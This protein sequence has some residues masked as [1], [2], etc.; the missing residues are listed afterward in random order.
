MRI[1]NGW[2]YSQHP[3]DEEINWAFSMHPEVRTE[4][5]IVQE[6]QTE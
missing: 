3:A 1:G 6:K 4:R 2:E 5:I